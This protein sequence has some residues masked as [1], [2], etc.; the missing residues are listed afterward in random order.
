MGSAKKAAKSAII[1]I[2]FSLISKLLGFLREVLI[3][4]NFGSGME[5]DTYFVALSATTVLMGMVAAGLNTTLIPILTEIEVKNGHDKKIDYMNNLINVVNILA[6][7]FVILGW[8]LSP[9][10]IRVMG[11][12]FEGEQFQ[13]AVNLTRIGLPIMLF[14]GTRA[15]FTGYLQSNESFLAPAAVGLPFNAVYILYLIFLSPSFGIKGLMVASVLAALAQIFIQIPAAKK[16]GYKY[17]FKV[18]FKDRYIKKALLLT[19]PVMVGTAI[20]ELNMIVDKTMASSLQEGSISSLNY[21]SKLNGIILGV[22]IAAVTTVIFPMLSKESNKDNMDGI[23]IIMSHG[24]NII[25]LITLPATVGLIILSEPIVRLFF[26]RGAFDATATVMTAKAL[27]FYAV[28][29]VGMALM[30]MLNKV[31]YSMQDT[32]T[33]MINSAI[34]VGANIGL[35]FLFIK[36]LGHGGLALATSISTTIATIL[37]IRDL[38]KRVDDIDHSTNRKCM[39]KTLVASIIM[40]VVVYF[41]YGGLNRVFIGGKVIE[42]LVLIISVAIGAMVYIGL[43]YLFRVEEIRMVIDRMRLKLGKSMA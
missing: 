38:D 33:P 7:F 9:M 6:V 24:I 17:R 11:K 4:L 21:A 40:G 2:I 23:N 3:A 27:I 42:L 26:Q 22:F 13:L 16:Q 25:L 14:T 37:L 43:C 19:L 1:I 41:L 35:N 5:T 8:F 31:Y 10:I 29:L 18:D 32:K 28:G 30:L 39:V 34:A 15:I 20:N 36:P 12:G